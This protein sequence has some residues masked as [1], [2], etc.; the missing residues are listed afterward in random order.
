ML[1]MMVTESVAEEGA[2]DGEQVRS[3]EIERLVARRFRVSRGALQAA[4]RCGGTESLA[5]HVAMYL[6]R[7]LLGHG[8]REIARR[9]MRHPTTVIYAC[10]RIE[11]LR[12]DPAFDRRIGAIERT[13]AARA[14]EGRA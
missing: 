6:E 3:A 9:F 2:V 13:V 11:D 12:D 7:V 8:Y 1:E 5:R 4:G 14:G 10:R